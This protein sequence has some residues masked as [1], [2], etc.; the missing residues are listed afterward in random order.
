MGSLKVFDIKEFFGNIGVAMFVFEGNACVINVRAETINTDK[1]P[2]ILTMAV[3]TVITL[4]MI[5]ATIAYVTYKGDCDPIFVLSLKP[6]NGFVTFIYF[7]V[8]INAFIS[9][10]V[11]I[12]AAFDIA[13]QHHFF[14]EGSHTKLKKIIMRSLVIMCITGV[15][16]IIPDFTTFLDISGS[17]GAGMIAFVLPP[18]LYN[19][20]FEGT[21]PAWKKYTNWLICAFGVVGSIFSVTQS[22]I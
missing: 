14:R 8:C 11:Q 17:L 6:V 1:Y 10:P 16:L 4:F 3:T 5:F 20:Q 22:I 12:L 19:K 13:E 9:Y 15:A 7:C 18:I 2:K 21:I